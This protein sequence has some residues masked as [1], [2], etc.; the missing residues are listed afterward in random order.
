M[1]LN[2]ISEDMRRDIL[3]LQQ[4]YE[5]TKRMKDNDRYHYWESRRKSN[6]SVLKFNTIT[7][8]FDT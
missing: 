3:N 6:L 1:T 2:R 7:L 8:L 5:L 4:Y